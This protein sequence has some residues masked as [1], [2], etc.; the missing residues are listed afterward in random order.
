MEGEESRRPQCWVG[1]EKGKK[2]RK[3]SKKKANEQESAS[4]LSKRL[5]VAV[6]QEL[7][8]RVPRRVNV[9]QGVAHFE[10]GSGIILQKHREGGSVQE[11]G[12]QSQ[13]GRKANF[14]TGQN[15]S[16][17][18]GRGVRGAGCSSLRKGPKK[19]EGF[20]IRQRSQRRGGQ[21]VDPAAPRGTGAFYPFDGCEW[22]GLQ[23]KRPTR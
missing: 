22:H 11:S 2:E 20:R 3:K 8:L 4:R 21:E 10:F 5:K 14:P 18:G 12:G 1:K 16:G 23:T 6:H 19:G 13:S 7:K 15:G 9:D 17:K